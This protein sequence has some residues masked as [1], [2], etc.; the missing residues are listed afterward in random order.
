[1]RG[2]RS[3]NWG[4]SMQFFVM[5]SSNYKVMCRTRLLTYTYKVTNILILF[6]IPIDHRYP[7]IVLVF[8]PNGKE[9]QQYG[10]PGG[11]TTNILTRCPRTP[12][13]YHYRYR[14][15]RHWPCIT[16]RRL[17]SLNAFNGLWRRR[18]CKITL[19]ARRAYPV[20]HHRPPPRGVDTLDT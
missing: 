4:V 14:Y 1:M 7:F 20:R 16:R 15:Y 3:I 18:D 17:C 11:Y 19:L 6:F 2:L 13:Y 9:N 5:L 10:L 8:W 12:Y